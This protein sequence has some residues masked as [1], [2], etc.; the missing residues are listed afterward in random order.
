MNRTAIVVVLSAVLLC[1]TLITGTY[2]QN[3]ADPLLE[4]AA[5]GDAA[6]VKELLDKGADVNATHEKTGATALILASLKGHAAVVKLLL[7]R[8]ADVDIRSARGVSAMMAASLDAKNDEIQ[9]MLIAGGA[10][11][12]ILIETTQSGDVEGVRQLLAEGININSAEKS[13][14]YTALFVASMHG[15]VELVKFLLEKGANANARSAGGVTPLMAAS[16]DPEN[17]DVAELLIAKG[18]DVNAKTVSGKTAL[19]LSSYTDDMNVTAPKGQ[20][21]GTLGKPVENNMTKFLKGKGAK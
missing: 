2:A 17:V 3:P 6:K 7:E 14:G 16:L 5:K 15:H 18:A 21:K 19:Q 9:K 11:T 1:G 12:T 13:N 4:A 20:P 10:G 8:N